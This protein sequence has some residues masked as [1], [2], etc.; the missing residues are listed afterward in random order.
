MEPRKLGCGNQ[1]KGRIVGATVG[2]TRLESRCPFAEDEGRLGGRSP[3][4]SAYLGH[5]D[6][7]P[8]NAPAQSNPANH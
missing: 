1:C 5:F 2:A 4:T 7:E 3:V 8:V 6:Q